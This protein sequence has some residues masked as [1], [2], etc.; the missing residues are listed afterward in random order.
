VKLEAPPPRQ[1]VIERD[2]RLVVV[3][4]GADAPL[5]TPS[6]RLT[7]D[8]V[9]SRFRQTAFDGRGVLETRGWY[10]LKG[11]RRLTVDKT[12]GRIVRLAP[13]IALLAAIAILAGF[14]LLPLALALIPVV[15]QPK[16]WRAVR[17]RITTYLDRFPPAV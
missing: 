5:S 3:D 16:P 9:R 2:G 8:R 15:F 12:T 6:V 14:Y 13:A 4:R 17:L 1:R 7:A 10:D 11:P